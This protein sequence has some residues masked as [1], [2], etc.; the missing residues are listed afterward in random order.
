M[1]VSALWYIMVGPSSP[2]V[3]VVVISL[4]PNSCISWIR[5]V[6]SL[7]I[8]VHETGRGSIHQGE[9]VFSSARPVLR[10]RPKG[11][12]VVTMAD[13][14]PPNR[15]PPPSTNISASIPSPSHIPS[16]I[17]MAS[18]NTLIISGV[19]ILDL[20]YLAASGIAMDMFMPEVF[21][22]PRLAGWVFAMGTPRI[23]STARMVLTKLCWTVS[24]YRRER[25]NQHKSC[26]YKVK[27]RSM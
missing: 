3:Q 2:V 24:R 26:Q 12:H 19:K 16:N 23:S 25:A 1:E 17:G 21:E 22:R 27:V 13:H 20:S 15:S 9:S 5:R 6:V 4:R 14:R 11:T 8:H 7:P 10:M 18:S